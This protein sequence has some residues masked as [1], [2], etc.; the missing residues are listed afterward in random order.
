VLKLSDLEQRAARR[1]ALGGL[2]F[3]EQIQQAADAGGID[4]NCCTLW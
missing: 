1:Q 3:A 2:P 4:P